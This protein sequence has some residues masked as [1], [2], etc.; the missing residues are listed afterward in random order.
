MKALTDKARFYC[1]DQ[2]NDLLYDFGEAE[3]QIFERKAY[4]LLSINHETAKEEILKNLKENCVLIVMDWVMK[5]FQSK[6]REKQSDK[7]STSHG[8]CSESHAQFMVFYI[9]LYFQPYY[10]QMFTVADLWLLFE[11]PSSWSQD[12][13]LLC[14]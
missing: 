6:Y 13:A 5:F 2:K 9:G 10:H 1:H 11:I 4:T 8:C 7:A 12:I 14:R 3:E